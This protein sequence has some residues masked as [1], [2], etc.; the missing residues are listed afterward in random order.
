MRPFTKFPKNRIPEKSGKVTR[1]TIQ[2]ALTK[3]TPVFQRRP[4]DCTRSKQL[5]TQT[6]HNKNLIFLM[7]DIA[8]RY[9]VKTSFANLHK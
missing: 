2:K 1:F 4:L 7:A 9:T 5:V 6:N 3:N 8:F